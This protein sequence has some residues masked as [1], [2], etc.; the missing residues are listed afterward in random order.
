MPEPPPQETAAATEEPEP[1]PDYKLM[2]PLVSVKLITQAVT[3]CDNPAAAGTAAAAAAAA[4]PPRKR[5]AGAAAAPP[6]ATGAAAAGPNA[7][8]VG[9]RKRRSA[10]GRPKTG[11]QL[12]A[13]EERVRQKAIGGPRRSGGATPR[14]FGEISKLVGE[15]WVNLGRDEQA[16]WKERAAAGA[17]A[18][19]SG[20]PAHALPPPDSVPEAAAA[21]AFPARAPA[22]AAA[23]AAGPIA[24]G[25][26][27]GEPPVGRRPGIDLPVMLPVAAQAQAVEATH[28]DRTVPGNRGA[29]R[30]EGLSQV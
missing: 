29:V 22:P 12:F 25:D 7:G 11:Y 26:G 19:D 8:K 27:G 2:W 14:T 16:V 13:V 1:E 6:A 5:R 18:N 21:G 9:K 24:D 23:L 3:L 20:Q 4:K 28:S 17:L 15:A 30:A 10:A